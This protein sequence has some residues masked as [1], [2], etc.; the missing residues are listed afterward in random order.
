MT[1]QPLVGQGLLIAQASRSHSDTPHSLRPFRTRNQP[2]GREYTTL[3]RDRLPCSGVI[4]THDLRN[5][6]ATHQ[7]Q[8][9]DAR[10][11]AQC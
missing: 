1:Q 8:T 2:R 10:I 7:C 6:S 5:R 4:W 11:L 9:S 3:T